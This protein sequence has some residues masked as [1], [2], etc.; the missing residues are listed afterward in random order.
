MTLIAARSDP[1]RLLQACG[2]TGYKN[3]MKIFGKNGRLVLKSLDDI[4]T[5]LGLVEAEIREL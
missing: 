2:E 4:N 3:V 5:V 1:E